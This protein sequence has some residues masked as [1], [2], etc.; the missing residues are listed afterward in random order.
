[1]GFRLVRPK[2]PV[3]PPHGGELRDGYCCGHRT[4]DVKSVIE[5]RGQHKSVNRWFVEGEWQ[6]HIMEHHH[7]T[8]VPTPIQEE[9]DGDRT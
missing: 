5:N 6:C 3:G 8:L 4:I 9:P 1:M 2:I 7:G